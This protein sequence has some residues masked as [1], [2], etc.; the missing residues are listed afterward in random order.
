MGNRWRIG[1][2]SA[3]NRWRIGGNS[4]ENRR[5]IG[6]KSMENRSEIDKK[7]ILKKLIRNRSKVNQNLPAI[8]QNRSK[9]IKN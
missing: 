1:G 5:K 9:S 8:D 6:G 3:E 4:V 2:E 7:S